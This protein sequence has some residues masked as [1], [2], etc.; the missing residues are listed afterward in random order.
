MMKV[1]GE[2]AAYDTRVINARVQR[3]EYRRTA[4][5]SVRPFDETR[6]IFRADKIARRTRDDRRWKRAARPGLLIT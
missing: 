1:A 4:A 5:R 2:S 3:V 6:V